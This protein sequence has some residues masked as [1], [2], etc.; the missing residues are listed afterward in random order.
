MSNLMKNT[1]YHKLS[2]KTKIET[3]WKF[4]AGLEKLLKAQTINLLYSKKTDGQ[5]FNSGEVQKSAEEFSH[6]LDFRP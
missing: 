4:V 3:I 6:G 5:A 1:L 2:S